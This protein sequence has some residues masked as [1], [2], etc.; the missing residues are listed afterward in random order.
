[1][2]LEVV[3]VLFTELG[4]YYVWYFFFQA[5]DGIR[6]DLV[7]G[8][9][10]CALPICP[11]GGRHMSPTVSVI[12]PAWNE[13][14]YLPALLES[15][16][17]QTVPPLEILIADSGSTD[18]TGAVASATGAQVVPGERKGPGEGR[19]RGAGAARGD[20]LLFADADCVLP[21]DVIE[22]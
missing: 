2:R 22:T 11:G 12:V 15:I 5:E 7:T 9:Q 16:R 17:L 8:V 20:V 4:V 14:K 3:V 21:P 18:D 10:T 13:A 6:D 19:N 1:M